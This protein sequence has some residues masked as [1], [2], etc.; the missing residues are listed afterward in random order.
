MDLLLDH[1][2]SQFSFMTGTPIVVFNGL[3]MTLFS[4]CFL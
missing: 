4:I 2:S 1:I 3:V